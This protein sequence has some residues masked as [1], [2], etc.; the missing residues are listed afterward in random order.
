MCFLHKPL[1]I[2]VAEGETPIT[3][4]LILLLI[5]RSAIRLVETEAVDLWEGKTDLKETLESYTG[6][7]G[8]AR[9][10]FDVVLVVRSSYNTFTF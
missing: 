9:K 8:N 10:C 4:T 7:K 1:P 6:N 5:S 2:R 3:M